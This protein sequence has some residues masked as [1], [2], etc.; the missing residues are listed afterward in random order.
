MKTRMLEHMNWIFYS[1][2][3]LAKLLV[4]GSLVL[5]F[6]VAIPVIV[7][8]FLLG[9]FLGYLRDTEAHPHPVWKKQFKI[10]FTIKYEYLILT[11]AVIT[12]IQHALLR[13]SRSNS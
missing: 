13:R 2:I 3:Y 10:P 5:L 6:A 1:S 8:I 9:M 11:P 7:S 12:R 4:I